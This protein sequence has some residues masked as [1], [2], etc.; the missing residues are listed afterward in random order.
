M[1]CRAECKSVWILIRWP[2]QKSTD[3]NEKSFKKR[4]NFSC[5]RCILSS[6]D[7]QDQIRPNTLSGLIWIQTV[8]H[9]NSVPERIFEKVNFKNICRRQKDDE[10]LPSLQRINPESAGQELITFFRM[11][12]QSSF[13]TVL[14]VVRLFNKLIQQL[15]TNMK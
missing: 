13:L 12:L 3:L 2:Q 14:N 7:N 6:A 8:C 5:Q 9:S 1:Y 11:K 10:K 15:N 4:I